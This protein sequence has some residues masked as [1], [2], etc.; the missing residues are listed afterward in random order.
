MILIDGYQ[1]NDPMSVFLS[2]ETIVNYG[3]KIRLRAL[4]F[5]PITS[6][7]PLNV[8]RS[9]KKVLTLFPKL[10][11][12]SGDFSARL[13]SAPTRNK[14]RK[15]LQRCSNKSWIIVNRDSTHDAVLITQVVPINSLFKD[16]GQLWSELG[17]FDILSVF[18]VLMIEDVDWTYI[19]RSC[20]I[21][22][23]TKAGLFRSPYIC[24]SVHKFW[25]WFWFF[26]SIPLS[27]PIWSWYNIHISN[28]LWITED[29][30]NEAAMLTF[31][32]G[33]LLIFYY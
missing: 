33:N 30:T 23:L 7:R 15:N 13:P 14:D 18:L 22:G 32:T 9:F 3:L 28:Q 8:F 11:S 1:N 12:L 4:R 19:W 27:A 10:R 26:K 29:T 6:I 21:G 5:S 20:M 24:V 31:K 16:I 25:F 2:L 17:Q